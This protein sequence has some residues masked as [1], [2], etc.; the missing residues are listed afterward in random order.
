MG[1]NSAFKELSRNVISPGQLNSAEL[2]L[3]GFFDKISIPAGTKLFLFKLALRRIMP[4]THG[5]KYSFSLGS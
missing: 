3:Y 4:P 2:L 5:G 1:F